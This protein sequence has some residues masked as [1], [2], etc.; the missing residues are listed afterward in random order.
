MLC[1]SY[2]QL[3]SFFSLKKKKLLKLGASCS[4]F[5]A[6]CVFVVI[7]FLSPP[8]QCCS[9]C[10]SLRLNHKFLVRADI[11]RHPIRTPSRG[12]LVALRRTIEVP[13]IRYYASILSNPI[14]RGFKLLVL[15]F[16]KDAVEQTGLI[17]DGF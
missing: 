3:F 16:S 14:R 4:F 12:G 2:R 8:F 17:L 9:F 6:I 15:K 1:V 10:V 5:K 7:I 11:I 13:G